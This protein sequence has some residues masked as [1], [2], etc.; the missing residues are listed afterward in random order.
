MSE[1][2]YD[3]GETIVKNVDLRLPPQPAP[4]FFMGGTLIDAEI[5]EA[6]KTYVGEGEV[7]NQAVE[8]P[9]YVIYCSQLAGGRVASNV[10]QGIERCFRKHG[11]EACVLEYDQIMKKFIVRN[12]EYF[13]SD[14]VI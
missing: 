6:I 10:F 7:V 11:T 4:L 5:I 12:H 3:C 9:K 13:V 1:S 14:R 2:S 8:S